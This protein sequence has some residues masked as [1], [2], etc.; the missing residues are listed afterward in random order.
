MFFNQVLAD[1][2]IDRLNERKAL[3][4]WKRFTGSSK[5]GG[6]PV[7]EIKLDKEKNLIN[8]AKSSETYKK[9]VDTFVDAE[10]IEVEKK[11]E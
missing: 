2:E 4:N 7:K 10:L 3:V 1:N 8:E 11:Y 5:K 9:I 6:E